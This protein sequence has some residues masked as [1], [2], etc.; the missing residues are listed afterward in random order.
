MILCETPP[1]NF[2]ISYIPSFMIKELEKVFAKGI[3][4]SHSDS[5]YML[6]Q[7]TKTIFSKIYEMLH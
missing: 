3:E 6:G 7:K 1:L 4:H 5:K 2:N